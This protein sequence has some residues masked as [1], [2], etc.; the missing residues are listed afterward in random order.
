VLCCV[1]ESYA[2]LPVHWAVLACVLWRV[3]IPFFLRVCWRVFIN[4]GYFI[5]PSVLCFWHTVYFLLVVAFY[6]CQYQCSQLPQ[7]E[8]II[9]EMHRH[10]CKWDGAALKLFFSKAL[11][12]PFPSRDIP[13]QEAYCVSKTKYRNKKILLSSVLCSFKFSII[14]LWSYVVFAIF[15]S[16]FFLLFSLFLL[17][18]V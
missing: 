2:D 1:P 6:G 11:A 14:M 5:V 10:S 4:Q 17:C 8:W 15:G 7:V 13:S 3:D 9:S 18:F 16:V 12:Q